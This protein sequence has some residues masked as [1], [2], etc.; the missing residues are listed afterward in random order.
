MVRPRSV[1]ACGR[2]PI[3]HSVRSQMR[4]SC[5]QM[6]FLA[7]HR[8]PSLIRKA[9]DLISGITSSP[10]PEDGQTKEIYF[11]MQSMRHLDKRSGRRNAFALLLLFLALELSA[12][13][14]P[15][16]P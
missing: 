1:I 4:G 12:R 9:G 6:E 13:A 10:C 8:Q 15:V 14:V 11:V 3:F 7:A 16:A 2:R 5:S